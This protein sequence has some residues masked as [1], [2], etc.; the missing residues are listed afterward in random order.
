MNTQGERLREERERLGFNQTDF[1][2]LGGLTKLTQLN[3][4]QNKRAPDGTYL[5]AIAKVGADVQYIITGQRSGERLPSREAALLDNY[6]QSDERG[7]RII[8][9]TANLAAEPCEDYKTKDAG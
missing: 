4:E 5:A 3:Y 7:K 8:E 9:Q 2:A 6:R 1:A